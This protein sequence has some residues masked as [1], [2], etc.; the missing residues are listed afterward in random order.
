MHAGLD[1]YQGKLRA[2]LCSTR[3]IKHPDSQI[4]PCWCPT[5]HTA[6]LE[7]QEGP[8]VKG[9]SVAMHAQQRVKVAEGHAS[10]KSMSRPPKLLSKQ[11]TSTSGPS[12]PKAIT[13]ACLSTCMS[14]VM[15]D[16][17]NGCNCMQ[18]QHI[19]HS[20]LTDLRIGQ[21]QLLRLLQAALSLKKWHCSVV[22]S[23][24]CCPDAC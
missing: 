10:F 3:S 4:N 16:V 7:A 12:L 19:Y 18:T 22:V 23:R 13:V 21:S 8:S 24:R 14:G 5:I 15:S 9:H 17:N 11:C 20:I 2:S 6:D 1:F